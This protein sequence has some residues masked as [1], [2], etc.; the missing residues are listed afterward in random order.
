MT[1]GRR[2]G[3]AWALAT[4]MASAACS[5]A[6]LGGG[7]DVG[8]DVA[9][10]ETAPDVAS[11]PDAVEDPALDLEVGPDSASDPPLPDASDADADEAQAGA[12]AE[13]DL[14]V[15]EQCAN[16]LDDDGDGRVDCH[17]PDCFDTPEC[18]GVNPAPFAAP[19]LW[20]RT[21]GDEFNGPEPGREACYDS[22]T[23]PPQCLT[24][25]W[26]VET[27]PESAWAALAD[28]DKCAWSALHLYNWMD[29]GQPIGEGVNAF[30]PERVT[31]TGGELVLSSVASLPEGGLS[32]GWSISQVMT[33]YDCGNPPAEGW[34]YSTDCP[35]L[36]GAVWS[37]TMGPV[38]G[39]VQTYGRFEVR[40]R[41]PVGKGS[42]PAHW[43]LPQ[44]GPWPGAG[45]IDIME[46][47]SWKPDEVGANFHDGV[48]LETASGTIHTHMSVGGMNQRLTRAQQHGEYHVFAVEWDSETLRFYVD[49]TPIGT[50]R[51]GRL[52][53]NTDLATGAYVGDFPV[54]VP[55]QDFYMILNSTVAA[56]GANDYP[57]PRD[58]PTQLHRIDYVRAWEECEDPAAEACPDGGSFDGANCRIGA[59][60]AREDW[61]IHERDLVYPAELGVDGCPDGG[62]RRGELCVVHDTPGARHAFTWDGSFYLQS[63]CLEATLSDSPRCYHPCGGLGE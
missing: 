34:A 50:V 41:L 21:W 58:F 16:G 9:E 26:H 61:F 18:E 52:L 43:M 42:W 49:S 2:V 29:N 28:L 40:A 62:E 38:T 32:A 6:E 27:C 53:R 35:I 19:R 4:L 23:T 14:P 56:F 33:R 22:A 48:T 25:Y 31:V 24:L 10:D 37:R 11:D 47:V 7:R 59:L 12:D 1:R 63:G 45:E 60:P 46:A 51:E 5:E 15:G 57:D 54:E 39:L 17:D 36:S 3:Y 8:G 55:D 44:D 13:P 30:R 20:R